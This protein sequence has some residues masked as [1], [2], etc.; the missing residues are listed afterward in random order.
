[1]L[2]ENLLNQL[3]LKTGRS[4]ILISDKVDLKCTLVKWD[5]EEYFI[6]IKGA[7]QQ[8]YQPICTKY[9][10]PISSNITLKDLKAYIDSNVVVV[11]YL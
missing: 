8:K 1:M 10:H 5:K 4:R 7:I 6:I 11:G 2:E 3:P 9:L